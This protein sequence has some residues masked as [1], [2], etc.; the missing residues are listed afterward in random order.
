MRR[1]GDK[2][3]VISLTLVGIAYALI[4]TPLIISNLQKQQDVR[5]RASTGNV[6]TQSAT[7]GTATTSTL[8]TID[9]SG[10]MKDRTSSGGTKIDRAKA[11]AVAFVDL[12]TQNPN[13]RV[14]LAS[15]ATTASSDY[16][17]T[18]NFSALKAK[19]FTLQANGDTCIECAI[20]YA[21]TMLKAGE[22]AGIKHSIVLLTDGR[23]N[24]IDGSSK[25]V[26]TTLAE[27]AALRSAK[28]GYPFQPYTIFVIG[29]GND[30]NSTFL[31]ELATST[32]GQYY[33][34]PTVDNL[35]QIY[36]Q[37]AG[38]VSQGSISGYVFRDTNHNGNWEE[39][40]PKLPDQPIQLTQEGYGTPKVVK[41]D[42][43]GHY[44]FTN[45]CNGNY[46]V[47]QILEAGWQQTAPTDPNGYNL[48]INNGTAHE[49][50]AFGRIQTSGGNGPTPVASGSGTRLAVTIALDGIGT[51]GD[52]TN[53][54]TSTLSNKEPLH[55]TV[56]ASVEIY[57]TSNKLI[58]AGV[59]EVNYD[60]AAGNYSG[61][62]PVQT[63]FP[64]G[65]YTVKIK[66]D[67]RLRKQVVGIQT[68]TAGQVSTI[69]P[70]ALI[71]GDANNDNKLNILDYNFV[72][73]CYSDLNSAVD[74]NS[75]EKKTITDFNDD[76]GVNQVDYNLFLRELSTQAGE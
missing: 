50:K 61:V 48:T 5:S 27:L 75:A 22:R 6:T 56:G 68:I 70:T 59:G 1:F 25:Q 7:C 39:G 16:L 60:A 73:G 41:S 2:R 53:P 76:G 28:T 29:I 32:D 52:N 40:E 20:K 9:R 13:N 36:A 21:N 15:Y 12:A 26:N 55:R 45:L 63:G 17:L 10:S 38:V 23:A 74:C 71:A 67:G 44:I 35:T 66:V 58:A 72:I 51:R 18:N 54:N 64:S 43:T 4:V 69:T 3:K 47:K 46:N 42:A 19:I 24:V 57:D 33:Y 62:L 30:V 8:L 37:I 14:G 65:Q 31:R 34:S 11:G 49:G